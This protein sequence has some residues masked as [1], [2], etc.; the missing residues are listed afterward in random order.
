[1]LACCFDG[2][3]IRVWPPIGAGTL[4]PFRLR[5]Q[6]VAGV[7]QWLLERPLER[8]WAPLVPLALSA[9]SSVRRAAAALLAQLLFVP[10]AERAAGGPAKYAAACDAQMGAEG[11]RRVL[12][13]PPPFLDAFAFPV[14]AAPLHEPAS[15]AVRSSLADPEHRRRVADLLEQ[16]RG[17]AEEVDD[18]SPADAASALRAAL[19]AATSATCHA[20]CLAA[21]CEARAAGC[22]PGG[23]VALRGADWSPTLRR[24]LTASPVTP[25]DAA[26][27]GA[28]M[29]LL[30]AAL[31]AGAPGVAAPLV[32][33]LETAAP[34]T[35]TGTLPPRATPL[36][37]ASADGPLA[38]LPARYRPAGDA[39]PTL[40]RNAVAAELLALLSSLARS[41]PPAPA[42]RALLS[43][44]LLSTLLREQV[45]RPEADYACRLA[46]LDAIAAFAD[47][48]PL[49]DDDTDAAAAG[50]AEA[51]RPLVR[52]VC[53]WA[54]R[55]AASGKG[56]G[57]RLKALVRA[58]LSALNK[59]T[60]A[61]P[62][63][64]WAPVWADVGGTFWLS[65]L[66]DDCQVSQDALYLPVPRCH[67]RR[68]R[69]IRPAHKRLAP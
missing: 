53:Q 18:R 62:P 69:R 36:A 49:L 12:L 7:R 10:E 31:D 65:R 24:L 20:D 28:L 59:L 56:T 27:W 50:L 17:L 25:E 40:A 23:A 13:L 67:Q 22:G 4:T 66:A 9:I 52:D 64:A 32:E 6:N 14:E 44:R 33:A 21:L 30:A 48:F 34:P 46:A 43:G 63:D 37:L 11:P 1:M 35:L 29:P 42:A 68:R 41:G 61:L 38:P 39:G 60:R 58:G 3:A 5:E 51:V 2:A 57:F 8:V 19:D 45:G 47:L 15:A 16:R 54:A 26:L 55:D